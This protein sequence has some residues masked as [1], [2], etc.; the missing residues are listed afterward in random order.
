MFGFRTRRPVQPVDRRPLFRPRLEPLEDRAMPSSTVLVATPNTASVT[1]AVTITAYVSE[2]GS[3][4]VQPGSGSPAGTV[5]FFDGS[6]PLAVVAV[7]RSLGGQG[8]AVF[9][10]SGLSAGSHAIHATYSGETNPAVPGSSTAPSAS[11]TQTVTVSATATAGQLTRFYSDGFNT[12][13]GLGTGNTLL[14]LFGVSDYLSAIKTVSGPVQQQLTQTYLE[15][16]YVN[17]Y[18]LLI[19]TA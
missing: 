6:T 5:T 12:A 10:T 17:Y 8:T 16:F 4:N 19:A 1:Q 15:S 7:R 2:T 13:Y 11:N 3:D 18:L 9:S 14:Y